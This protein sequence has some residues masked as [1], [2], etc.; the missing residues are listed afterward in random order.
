MLPLSGHFFS[1]YMGSRKNWPWNQSSQGLHFEVNYNCHC[2]EHLSSPSFPLSLMICP[3]SSDWRHCSDS[4]S[5]ILSTSPTPR[6]F[7]FL[8][9]AAIGMTG[10][11]YHLLPSCIWVV[12]LTQETPPIY[13]GQHHTTGVV[14][15]LGWTSKILTPPFFCIL[16][17]ALCIF[18][19]Q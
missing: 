7:L 10:S 8:S 19:L 15:H 1:Y 3:D 14:S 16:G 18:S 6:P 13:V 9:A 17:R 4:T 2:P 11:N 12:D 5:A